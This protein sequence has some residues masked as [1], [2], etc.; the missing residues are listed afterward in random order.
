MKAEDEQDKGGGV[1]VI[2]RAATILNILGEHPEGLSLGKIA[3]SAQLPRSTVQR[4]VGALESVE[5]IRGNGKAGV[6]LGPAFLKLVTNAHTDVITAMRP[7]LEALSELTGETVALSRPAGRNL[8]AIHCAVASGE[9]QIVPRLGF[10]RPLYS[11]SA[12]RVLLSLQRDEDVRA[13]FA[14]EFRPPADFSIQTISTL[15]ERLNEIRKNG[16]SYDY[17]EMIEGVN[18]IAIGLDTQ[19]GR[20]SVSMLL[21]LG[22]YE[23]KHDFCVESL[24]EF[25]SKLLNE[26]GLTAKE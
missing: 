4:L 9:L 16:I 13:L 12:G 23:R 11:T 1:Q 3:Q 5:L 8:T 14:E 6:T 10:A 19:I 21:P 7:R 24:M 2:S 18:T 26:I 22:R 17:G 25:R 15:I 20:F